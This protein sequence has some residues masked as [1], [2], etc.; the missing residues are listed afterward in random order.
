MEMLPRHK[1]I[2]II[3]SNPELRDVAFVTE[4][5]VT[6]CEHDIETMDSMRQFMKYRK[7]INDEK[8]QS[9]D[10]LMDSDDD[11]Q[12]DLI[13]SIDGHLNTLPSSGWELFLD[14]IHH[15]LKNNGFFILKIM[16]KAP[17]DWRV[18]NVEDIVTDWIYSV[19][20]KDVGILFINLLLFCYHHQDGVLWNEV[21]KLV[22]DR[23]ADGGW[24]WSDGERLEFMEKFGYLKESEQRLYCMEEEI[25]R[26]MLSEKRFYFQQICWGND[27]RDRYKYTPI[28]VMGKQSSRTGGQPFVFGHGEP[29]PEDKSEKVFW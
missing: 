19:H 28:Y 3:G 5:E 21:L 6:L 14:G 16:N 29:K 22:E 11:E 24:K 20:R 25:L 15:R 23:S 26:E 10:W 8:Q 13:L 17:G 2:L 18:L 27:D 12:Y 1:R 4:K 7:Y 9:I